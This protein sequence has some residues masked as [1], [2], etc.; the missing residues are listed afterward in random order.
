MNLC[1]IGLLAIPPLHEPI[2]PAHAVARM[3]E[4]LPGV[5]EA[6][7]RLSVERPKLRV[8]HIRNTH[9][10][11]RQVV[12]EHFE[13]V[14]GQKLHEDLVEQYYVDMVLYA[15]EIRAEQEL[16]LRRM[17]GMGMRTVLQAGLFRENMGAFG[18]A[19][20]HI[21]GERHERPVLRLY[22]MRLGP[23]ARLAAERLI[24]ILPLEEKA[25]YEAMMKDL[26]QIVDETQKKRE[27]A[28]VRQILSMKSGTVVIAAGAG[29]DF[30]YLLNTAEV[31]YIAVT[32]KNAKDYESYFKPFKHRENRIP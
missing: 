20:Q 7:V 27:E 6:E 5:V 14:L 4:G 22:C 28:M 19:L 15:D 29:H 13:R 1:L 31:D 21:R 8:V 32:T 23:A 30:T 10:A 24:M 17:A 2:Y 26:P 3:L 16:L 12:R 9:Y 11:P 18:Y 25:A